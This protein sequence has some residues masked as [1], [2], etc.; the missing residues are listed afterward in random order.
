MAF[1]LEPLLEGILPQVMQ[2]PVTLFAIQTIAATILVLFTAE[3]LPKS[4]FLRSPNK[5]L[6]IFALPI[7][8]FYIILYPAV[9]AIVSLSKFMI[10]KI[11]RL[12]YSEDK[13]VFGLTDLNMYIK[14]MVTRQH[15]T[16]ESEVDTRIFTNALEFKTVKVRECLVPRPELEVV[17]LSESIEDLRKAFIDS[18]YS[19]ILVYKDSIDDIVG[20]CN[21]LD[22]FKKPG[23]I[24]EIMVPI[25]I[26]PEAMLANELM[27]QFITERK[28][29]A[30]V[31]DE[32]GGTSGIVTIED[33]I[34]EIFGEIEDE[35]DEQD[36]VEKDLAD[37]NYLLSARHEIDYLNVKYG[38][39][40]PEGDY[41]TLGG[42]IL[43]IVEDIPK[44]KEVI[45]VPPYT[46]TIISIHDNRIDQVKLHVNTNAVH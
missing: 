19:K 26:V 13:P 45:E 40:L 31:V 3:F 8:F 16:I 2:T 21:S 36:L 32:F 15:E 12:E 17:G 46:F 7:Y 10:E 24:E 28:S 27:I 44:T 41:D 39:Q 1:V 43:S 11:F 33:I 6:Y 29:I 5:M 34:E 20:Y 22:L 14:R 18:G 35:H 9:L 30:L 23:S 4:F 25:M 42:L 38:W 37:G